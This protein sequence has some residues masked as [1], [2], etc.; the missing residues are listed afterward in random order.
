MERRDGPTCSSSVGASLREP[1]LLP[2]V[3]EYSLLW[4]VAPH[5]PQQRQPLPWH[6]SLTGEKEESSSATSAVEHSLGLRFS[7]LF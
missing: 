4:T 1:T 3:S 2:Q 6:L 5:A 7:L